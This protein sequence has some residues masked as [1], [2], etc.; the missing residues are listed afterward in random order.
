MTAPNGSDGKTKSLNGAAVAI[1]LGVALVILLIAYWT[2]NRYAEAADVAA[3]LAAVVGPLAGLGAAAFGIQLQ[4]TAKAETR[5][6]KE[7][8]K[9]QADR[10]RSLRGDNRLA[11]ARGPGLQDLGEVEEELRRLAT[12]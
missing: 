11:A 1:V 3:I 8:V 10:I 12:R 9:S 6:T 2:I 5:I 7:G 4:A